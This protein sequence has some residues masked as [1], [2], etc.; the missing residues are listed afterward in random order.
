METREPG[1]RLLERARL[2]PIAPQHTPPMCRE[3]CQA[4]CCTNDCTNGPA[5]KAK[6]RSCSLHGTATRWKKPFPIK[7]SNE[8][9]TG[10]LLLRRPHSAQVSPANAGPS[11]QEWPRDAQCM[12]VSR[13][14]RMRGVGALAPQACASRTSSTPRPGKDATPISR[15][16]PGVAEALWHIRRG[17][18]EHVKTRRMHTYAHMTCGPRCPRC[19]NRPP[20]ASSSAHGQS[21]P[22]LTVT[23]R[24]FIS[25][26]AQAASAYRATP[27][28]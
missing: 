12:Q 7:R 6:D 3:A 5:Q 16:P 18:H 11:R 21:L 10:P 25:R 20:T 19:A 27:Y 24:Q 2:A 9:T 28:A 15:S 26:S 14:P 8:M 22:A 23:R 4:V 1:C 13:R 17:P